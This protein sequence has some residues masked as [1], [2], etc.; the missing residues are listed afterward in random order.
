MKMRR[1]MRRLRLR[2]R[3]ELCINRIKV[4]KKII[5]DASWQM[6]WY[7]FIFILNM[8]LVIAFLWSIIVADDQYRNHLNRDGSNLIQV[9]FF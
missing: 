4:S 1:L 6:S 2:P 8:F 3:L 5:G 7:L 9:H